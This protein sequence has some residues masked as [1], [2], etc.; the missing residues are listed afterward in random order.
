MTRREPQ[1]P[2]LAAVVA[3]MQRLSRR[4][5]LTRSG[6]AVGGLALGPAFLA[7]CGDDTTTS[8]PGTDTTPGVQEKKLTI[9][10][11]TAYI[12]KDASGTVDGPDTTIDRFQKATGVQVTYNEDFNDNN[13]VFNKILSPNLSQGKTVG[14]DIVTPTNWLVAR[15]VT[16][17]WVEELPL[18]QIP[19]HKNLEDQYLN[20]D[21]DV[22]A[23]HFM[24]WA[25]GVTGIA[26]DVTKTGKDLTSLDDL[27]DP[28]FKGRVGMLTELRDTIGLCM[29]LAGK[30]PSVKDMDGAQAALDTIEKAKN[31]GQVSKF[32]GNEYLQS[33]ESGDF[34]ACMGWSG[35]IQQ[36]NN[37][38]IRFAVPESGG[39]LFFD[40]MTIPKGSPHTQSA[41]KWMDFVY[42]P[43]NAAKITAFSQYA[44]PVKGLRDEL[45]KL[46]GDAAALADSPLLFPD[47]ATL[48]RL[49]VFWSLS[50]DDEA[51]LTTRFDSI[52]A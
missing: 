45:T 6:L 38:N 49:N 42:D 35:D 23:K 5:F 33:L 29:L 11:W 52:I 1:D 51:T 30:D 46:G 4:R 10:N 9:S 28:A 36:L 12:D 25:R 48:K 16:L 7:A 19:N 31:D 37:P 44:A 13:E 39:M 21:W 20:L 43:V 3:E 8:T 17:G 32:T 2:Q 22:G 24:P 26:Y 15:L 34:V 40:C 50:D 18:A 47:D 41:A 27:F 14:P